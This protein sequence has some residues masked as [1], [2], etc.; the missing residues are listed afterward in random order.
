MGSELF[1]FT[2]SYP[3]GLGE[4]WK[5]DELNILS[6]YYNSI[7][8]YPFTYGG[9]NQ[10]KSLQPN[11]KA[12]HPVLDTMSHMRRHIHKIF[13]GGRFRFY[14]SELFRSQV[15]KKRTWTISWLVASIQTELLCR[16]M[17][18]R[19]ISDHLLQQ[20]VLYFFWSREWAYVVPF[21]K[22]KGFSKIFVRFH[23]Y[24]LYEERESNRGY[25]PFRKPLLKSLNLAVL[26]SEQAKKYLHSKYPT[27]HFTSI[28]VPLGT[29]EKGP[30]HA[31][32]DG[33]FRIV[34]CSGVTEVKRLH[35]LTEALEFADH[36][37][38]WT[39][40]GDGPLLENLMN[41]AKT[42]PSNVK[43]HF[44]GKMKT[45]EVLEFYKNNV[46]DLFVNVSE[47]EGMPVSVI[48]AFSAHIP[49]IA[50]NV[51]GTAV[52]VTPETGILL[53]PDPLPKEI[54]TAIKKFRDLSSECRLEFRRR[55]YDHF[56]RNFFS[57]ENAKKL[58]DH[59]IKAENGA[60]PFQHNINQ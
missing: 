11:V 37:I 52:L 47:S 2:A 44:A 36:Q 29:I 19:K 7:T 38:E 32:T 59:F 17:Q 14:L 10:P 3:Y 28:V 24:D 13:T 55:A 40:I 33:I 15:Y 16:S 20:P 21:L 48:E 43:A 9:N 18:Y 46:F 23:G 34:T 25:I 6:Q 53:S 12:D 49:A 8:I 1:L 39:H 45:D 5:R 58:L 51:G 26:L 42:L 31:S 4:N 54:W 56:K 57:I 22:K 35:L 41:Q 30:S 50:T 60:K 27:V